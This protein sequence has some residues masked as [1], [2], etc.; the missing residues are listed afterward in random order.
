MLIADKKFVDFGELKF[1][2]SP[3]VFLGR[4]LGQLP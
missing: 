2:D 4:H 1:Q 3:I